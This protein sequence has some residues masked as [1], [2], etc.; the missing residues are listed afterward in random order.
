MEIWSL[1][2]WGWLFARESYFGWL[3]FHFNSAEAHVGHKFG[4]YIYL[5]HWYTLP[6]LMMRHRF[7]FVLSPTHSHSFPFDVRPM[8]DFVTDSPSLRANPHRFG[9]WFSVAHVFVRTIT[10][11]VRPSCSTAT[12]QVNLAVSNFLL[13]TSPRLLRFNLLRGV[14]ILPIAQI[15]KNNRDMFIK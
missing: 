6:T 9:G 10:S 3:G 14:T 4:V 15:W 8:V 7:P 13:L 12:K 2:V 11:C 5:L 1:R